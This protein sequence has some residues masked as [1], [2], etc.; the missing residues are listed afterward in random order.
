MKVPVQCEAEKLVADELDK[1]QQYPD[2][3]ERQK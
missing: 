2:S 3:D 1:L